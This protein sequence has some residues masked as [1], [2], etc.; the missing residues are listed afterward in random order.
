MGGDCT[1]NPD[2]WN[3][4]SKPQNNAFLIKANFYLLFITILFCLMIS[5]ICL[6]LLVIFIK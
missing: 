1:H 5:N 3:N 6:K 2:D 4:E